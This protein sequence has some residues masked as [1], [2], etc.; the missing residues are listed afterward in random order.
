MLQGFPPVI[1]R[2][3]RV[4]I[5]GSFPSPRSLEVGEYYGNK[6]NDF[7]KVFGKVVGEDL[8][9]A[10]FD[11]KKK[12]LLKH[13]IGLWDVFSEAKRKALQT[14]TLNTRYIMISSRCSMNILILR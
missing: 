5:L 10:S 9:D 11:M 2:N 4:L 3:V 8:H 14:A 6:G 13:H 12:I 1:D 7:W